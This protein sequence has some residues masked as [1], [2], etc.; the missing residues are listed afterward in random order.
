MLLDDNATRVKVNK[1]LDEI[2][3]EID[4]D[5]LAELDS[6]LVVYASTHGV[7]DEPQH[8]FYLVP[9]TAVRRICRIQPCPVRA[10]FSF[11]AV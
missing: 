1:K 9:M 8:T 4:R 11:V 6:I 10:F 2:A 3:E 5:R 7:M